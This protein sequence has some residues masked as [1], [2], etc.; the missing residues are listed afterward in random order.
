M[1]YLFRLTGYDVT[2]YGISPSSY[3]KR[4]YELSGIHFKLFKSGRW[5]PACASKTEPVG[6]SFVLPGAMLQ[7]MVYPL[8]S[9]QVRGYKLWYISFVS[10]GAMLQAMVYLLRLTRSEVTSYQVSI[11]NYSSLADGYPHVRVKSSLWVNVCIH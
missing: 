6:A 1:L 11:L 2:S 4:G 9:Y 10:P 8:S 5:I 3:Q 7:A